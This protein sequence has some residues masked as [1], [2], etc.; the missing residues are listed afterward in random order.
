MTTI[1]QYKGDVYAFD[2]PTDTVLD[3]E[4]VIEWIKSGKC[5]KLPLTP[6]EIRNYFQARR[7]TGDTIS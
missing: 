4:T 5:P 6:D 7:V 2:D 1:L 3:V